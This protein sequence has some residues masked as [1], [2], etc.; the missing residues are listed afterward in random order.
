M[1]VEQAAAAGCGR[2]RALRVAAGPA[3]A[4]LP[5]PM[6]APVYGHTTAGNPLYVAL[7]LDGD[8]SPSDEQIRSAYLRLCRENHPD[9]LATRQLSPEQLSAAVQRFEEATAAFRAL[10]APDASAAEASAGTGQVGAE[11]GL[12]PG[13]VGK[14][15]RISGVVACVRRHGRSLS[16]VN[17][18]TTESDGTGKLQVQVVFCADH[19]EPRTNVGLPYQP[20][21]TNK[22][23]IQSGD[24]VQLHARWT[25]LRKG[26]RLSLCVLSWQCQRPQIKPATIASTAR[27]MGKV[28]MGGWV[29]CPICPRSSMK[30]FSRQGG[31]RNH[32]R[33]KHIDL[34]ASADN[35]DLWCDDVERRA[36]LA[37]VFS[38]RGAG[39][40]NP[41]NGD[42]QSRMSFVSME[43][44]NEDPG[45][46]GSMMVH[47]ALIAARDGDAAALQ[48]QI[49]AGWTLFEPLS[50]DR[51]GASALD[52][53]SGGGHIACV[54]L[55]V[56][57]ASHSSA[58]RR[59]GR[60]PAHWAAR[61]GRTN[62]LQYLIS[63]GADPNTRTTNG[64]TMLMFAA[65]GG[66]VETC[67]VLK[68]SGAK[69]DARNAWDCDV[70]HFAAMGGSV[71]S[72][73]WVLNCG[74]NLDR[75][76]RSGHTALHKAA[77]AGHSAVCSF[78]IQHMNTEQIKAVGDHGKSL[79]SSKES[80]VVSPSRQE[81]G[82][83]LLSSR[84][85][86]TEA[87]QQRRRH[88]HLPST[89]ALKSNHNELCTMLAAKGL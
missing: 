38:R 5:R 55:L 7:G 56:P 4:V 18:E 28:A 20:F 49:A 54:R 3:A 14:D 82:P 33:A 52:W 72:C 59:D 6:A 26:K 12:A 40:T 83:T 45:G 31:L 2:R 60:G 68:G 53:A 34:L 11:A 84:T 57:L 78:L 62:V 44:A 24:V 65:Y 89:L 13:C 39:G 36:E 66:H 81:A 88:A 69:L 35:A 9:K 43:L 74:V 63:Q 85:Q 29:S 86:L 79:E 42:S 41:Q 51:R 77:E 87:Q 22:R 1:Y 58:C 73:L 50:L 19:F 80:T 48:E 8:T 61:H 15:V 32:L 27:R 67:Q 37:G 10:S 21:P 16:F 64:T 76:Q 75:R 25:A 23:D 30:R 47:P 46:L 70:G 71:D 17:I